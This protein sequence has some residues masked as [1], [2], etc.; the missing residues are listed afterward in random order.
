MQVLLLTPG[1]FC[2]R[3][4]VAAS[5]GFSMLSLKEV[6]RAAGVLEAR[7]SGTRL[8]RIVQAG[9]F[10]LIME[11]YGQAATHLVSL[12]CR[13]RFA[14][15]GSPGEMPKAPPIPPAFAQYLRARLG[16]AS[17]ESI[18]AAA[19]DRRM[20]V[21]LN[22][23]AGAFEIVLS[24]LGA[25]SN[26]YLLDAS[27][28]LLHAMRPLAETRRELVLGEP[29]TE[30][31]GSP[32]S[33]GADRWE[34]VP[35]ERYLEAVEDTYAALERDE[36]AKSLARRLE[37]A[38]N[39]E[40]DFLERKAAN[41]L[42]DLGEAAEAED[43]RRKGE[44]LKLALHSI[45]PGAESVAVTDYQ[46]GTPVVISLDP[47][48]S[49]SENLA[50]YFKRYQKELRGVGAIREQL[51]ALR[52]TQ[53]ALA[54]LQRGLSGMLGPSGLDLPALRL[55]AAEPPVRKL[56][57]RYY[58]D[59][60]PRARRPAAMVRGRKEIPGRL[61]PK[62][63]RTEQGLEIWV[64]R[65]EEGN[66]YLTTRLARG[67]DLFFHLEG[68]PG[69]HVILRTE[70]K[71]APPAESV[72]DAC[73][74]AVHFSK[75]KEARRADVHVAPVKNIKKPKGAKPGLVYVTRGKTIHL[76]RDPK[77]LENILASRL[78]E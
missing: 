44:L 5:Q 14:R 37:N 76:R 3:Q 36:E 40:A 52:N 10:R 24:I 2:L 32:R 53:A 41:L 13:P 42:A 78:D 45:R 73:E 63:Y 34:S 28:V 29:W 61:Q 27:A 35:D 55:L 8:Q 46:T 75:L 56:L 66:D 74:L 17:F 38:L 60:V 30:P 62:R 70:G 49:P 48:L 19:H 43:Y 7:L 50:A 58:P 65:S 15:I 31:E 39:K 51:Q 54:E 64:G 69:S 22:S 1:S 21:R 72:L 67:N 23:R 71:G 25:R 77:R 26:I 12:S 4:S 18:T 47:R 6:R 9:D 20:G 33:E 11:F 68:Y 59:R 57:S 16:R